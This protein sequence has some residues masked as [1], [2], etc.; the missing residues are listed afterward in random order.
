MVAF[1]LRL[2]F[3]EIFM[4]GVF[5]NQATGICLVHTIKRQLKDSSFFMF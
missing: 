5:E 4:L 2:K 1:L 3:F